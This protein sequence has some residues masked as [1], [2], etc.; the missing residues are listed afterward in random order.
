MNSNGSFIRMI[1]KSLIAFISNGRRDNCN[2]I[3]S[4]FMVQHGEHLYFIRMM[5]PYAAQCPLTINISNFMNPNSTFNLVL[6]HQNTENGRF[7]SFY[8]LGHPDA[9]TITN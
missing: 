5:Q 6:S 4:P 1:V 3:I 8:R 7:C 2:N 9:L